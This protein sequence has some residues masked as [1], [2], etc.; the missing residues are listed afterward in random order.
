MC[1]IDV[2]LLGVQKDQFTDIL[3]EGQQVL[4]K[5]TDISCCCMCPTLEEDKQAQLC[6]QGWGQCD[7]KN[8]KIEAVILATRVL[9]THHGTR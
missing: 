7:T 9:D 2:Y 6:P 8:Y 3:G 1:P 5:K 4:E